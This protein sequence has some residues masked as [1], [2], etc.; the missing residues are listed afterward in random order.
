MGR[1]I[2]IRNPESLIRS[3][4]DNLTWERVE[5]D[6]IQLCGPGLRAGG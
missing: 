4:L 3:L 5:V 2:A 6:M 1:S